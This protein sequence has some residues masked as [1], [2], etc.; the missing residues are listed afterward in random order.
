MVW[1]IVSCSFHDVKLLGLIC[2][3]SLKIQRTFTGNWTVLCQGHVTA[4]LLK[5]IH[6]SRQLPAWKQSTASIFTQ[7][8]L[9]RLAEFCSI[10][11]GWHK[12]Q[13]WTL[14]AESLPP[15]LHSEVKCQQNETCPVPGK[16]MLNKHSFSLSW[17]FTPIR[18][19]WSQLH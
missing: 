4:S 13:Q 11:N 19:G 15:A 8:L 14:E 2:W 6:Q 7:E 9:W 5:P 3:Q 17:S 1:Q 18:R 10:L 16:H 12:P